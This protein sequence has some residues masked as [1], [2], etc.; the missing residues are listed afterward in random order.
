[1]GL[2]RGGRLGLSDLDIRRSNRLRVAKDQNEKSLDGTGKETHGTRDENKDI[3]C[4]EGVKRPEKSIGNLHDEESTVNGGRVA[5]KNNATN[6]NERGNVQHKGG[7][8]AVQ[9][10]DLKANSGSEKPHH[11]DDGSDGE[12]PEENELHAHHLHIGLGVAEAGAKVEKTKDD[13]KE[14]TQDKVNVVFHRSVYS[15]LQCLRGSDCKE[16]RVERI[17]S[18]VLASLQ[19]GHNGSQVQELCDDCAKHRRHLQ[20][21]D[22]LEGHCDVL[23]CAK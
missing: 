13:A 14:R 16:D 10:S 15:P 9:T 8:H 3:K 5:G 17:K 18:A 2:L 1:M 11:A 22:I 20:H 12:L 23:V 6:V 21:K 19:D 7:D 4:K